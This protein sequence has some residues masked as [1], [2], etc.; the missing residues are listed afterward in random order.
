MSKII[1]NIA[2]L[3]FQKDDSKYRELCT[4]IDRLSLSI[5][6]LELNKLMLDKELLKAEMDL[7][8]LEEKIVR[9]ITKTR[10]R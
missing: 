8:N 4:L 9:T 10:R 6:E 1:T 5:K 7:R 3:T 2:E